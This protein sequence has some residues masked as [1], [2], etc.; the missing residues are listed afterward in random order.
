MSTVKKNKPKILQQYQTGIWITVAGNIAA[1]LVFFFASFFM[2]EYIRIWFHIAAAIMAIAAIA[3][4]IF[5]SIAKKKYIV[6]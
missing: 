1:A 4:L 5:W 6:K 3:L 2:P